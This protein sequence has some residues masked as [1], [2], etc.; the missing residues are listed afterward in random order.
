MFEPYNGAGAA[1]ADTTAALAAA[2]AAYR[3]AARDADGTAIDAARRVA[4]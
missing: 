2:R 3:D 1:L 4:P